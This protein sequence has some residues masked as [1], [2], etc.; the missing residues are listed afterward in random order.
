MKL[1]PTEQRMWDKLK[2]GTP[3]SKAEL[4]TCLGDQM[5]PLSNIYVFIHSLRGKVE[6]QG[7]SIIN[8]NGKYRLTRMISVGE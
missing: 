4:H 2:D 1:T 5:T 6:K 7:L 3:A 8:R